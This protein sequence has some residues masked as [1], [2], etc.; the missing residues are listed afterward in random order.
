MSLRDTDTID[1]LMLNISVASTSLS[2]VTGT[3][4]TFQL[5]PELNVTII[6]ME[7]K[8]TPAPE[9]ATCNYSYN[10]RWTDKLLYK[11]TT[12]NLFCNLCYSQN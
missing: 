7:S 6:G 9:E 5:L 8:S 10:I 3:L 11:I 4:K 12:L 2:Q 1:K